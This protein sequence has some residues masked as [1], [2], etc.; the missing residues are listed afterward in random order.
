MPNTI[1]LKSLSNGLSYQRNSDPENI[2]VGLGYV[3]DYTTGGAIKLSIPDIGRV[4][5]FNL[6]TDTITEN[7]NAVTGTVSEKFETLR[8]NIFV[9]AQY[10]S[11]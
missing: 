7:G 8:A 5:T 11:L 6:S 9:G 10:I 4:H 3:I 2:Y 1:N